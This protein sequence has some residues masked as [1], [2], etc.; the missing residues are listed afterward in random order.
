MS[1][2][3]QE[4]NINLLK[5]IQ[6]EIIKGRKMGIGGS[7]A[8]ALIFQTGEFTRHDGTRVKIPKGACDSYKSH[9]KKRNIG[10]IDI[11]FIDEN[12]PTK[13]E[14]W[15]RNVNL[16]K[17]ITKE[18]WEDS[19]KKL[20]P[21]ALAN[22]ISPKVSEIPNNARPA[23]GVKDD[24]SIISIH[25]LLSNKPEECVKLSIEDSEVYVPSLEKAFAHKVINHIWLGDIFVTEKLDGDFKV[26]YKA[27]KTIYSTKEI[28]EFTESVM[29]QEFSKNSFGKEVNSSLHRMLGNYKHNRFK[30]IAPSLELIDLLTRLAR[31]DKERV[32]DIKVKK[33]LFRVKGVRRYFDNKSRSNKVAAFVRLP[34]SIISYHRKEA[35]KSKSI[36]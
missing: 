26:L 6:E 15:V 1:S 11:F 8:V 2:A 32:F 28:T 23:F 4:A 30:P 10:D 35:C 25:I 33:A 17:E 24:N 16:F 29:C 27:L 36:A 13:E 19:F 21:A 31:H 3:K 20:S 22:A 34:N 14:R 9:I 7:L 5:Y 12:L 18:P